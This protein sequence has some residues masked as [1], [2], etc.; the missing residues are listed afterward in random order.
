MGSPIE[1]L[2][3][4]LKELK[5]VHIEAPMAPAAYVAKDSL[6]SHQCEKRPLVL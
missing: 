4:G 2:E 3:E 5:G 1:E 6:V